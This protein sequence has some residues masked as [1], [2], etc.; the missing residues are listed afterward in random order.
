[1]GGSDSRVADPGPLPPS[2]FRAVLLAVSSGVSASILDPTAD[3]V[4]DPGP[5]F[6]A[7]P[8][9]PP[10]TPLILYS[11]PVIGTPESSTYAL[12]TFRGRG[13]MVGGQIST[14]LVKLEMF[15]SAVL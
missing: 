10:P 14:T 7:I 4:P 5:Y 9:P 15:S 12:A 3:E 8:P 6:S 2:L 11:L 1:M 13:Y